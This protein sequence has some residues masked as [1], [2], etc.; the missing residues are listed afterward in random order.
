MNKL[1][2]KSDEFPP[3]VPPC[4]AKFT[5]SNITYNLILNDNNEIR[6]SDN[7]SLVIKS[8]NNCIKW[9]NTNLSDN[10]NFI[11]SELKK[12]IDSDIYYDINTNNYLIENYI[13]WK[14][15]N[16]KHNNYQIEILKKSTDSITNKSIIDMEYHDFLL[17]DIDFDN[18][19]MCQIMP[20]IYDIFIPVLHIDHYDYI[21]AIYIEDK[22]NI[23]IKLNGRYIINK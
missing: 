9:F 6:I 18:I 16:I 20:G 21:P 12:F 19:Y 17:E 13:H 11:N 5:E 8:I 14:M 22:F 4:D 1:F 3:L 7:F 10:K 2:I 15:N 23:R